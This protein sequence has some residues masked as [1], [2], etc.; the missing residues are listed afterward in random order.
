MM[1]IAIV[2]TGKIAGEALYALQYVD[3]IDVVAI[4]ARPHSLDKARTLAETYHIN[5][6]YTDYD[7][8]LQDEGIEF[9]YVGIV[10]SAHYEYGRKALMA[11][12]NVIMEKPFT[13]KLSEAEDLQRLAIEKSLYLFEAVTLFHMNSF[14]F[15]KKQLV[16]IGNIRMVQS[17]YS[18]YS[19]RYDR[20]MNG[21]VAPAFDPLLA[22]GALNDIN[23]Y[24][25]NLVVG[26]FGEPLEVKYFANHGSNGIDTSGICLLKYDGFVASCSGAK[27]SESPGFAIIQG[28]KGWIRINGI[29]STAEEIECHY[30][31]AIET[32]T[33]EKHPHRMIPEFKDFAESYA[34]GNYEL[35]KNQ[36]KRTI[37]VMKTMEMAHQNEE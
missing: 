2:G 12:K 8:M 15:L 30:G 20:Y 21:D 27:D 32:F 11:L 3:E 10:N 33:E 36:L 16:H 31:D 26:L 1:R 24:N 17:N 6:V 35:M 28:E 18:Q 19:S 22:G 34:A 4:C 13:A 9:V 5:K 7:E 23:I 25:L 37:S 29:P 14:E